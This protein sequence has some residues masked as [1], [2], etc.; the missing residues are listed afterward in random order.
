MRFSV[1]IACAELIWYSN[2][3]ERISSHVKCVEKEMSD[4]KVRAVDN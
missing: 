4:E 2:Q 3:S 1:G